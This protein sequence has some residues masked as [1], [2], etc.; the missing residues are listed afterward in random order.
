VIFDELLPNDW[1]ALDWAIPVA[2]IMLFAIIAVV[3]TYAV[4]IGSFRQ[5]LLLGLLKLSAFVLLAICLLEPLNRFSYPEPGANLMLVLADDSQSLQIKDRGQTESRESQVKDTISESS[6][7][8]RNLDSDFDVRRYQFDRRLRPVANFDSYAATQRGSDI[9]GNLELA[10]SRFEGRP[11]AGVLLFTDGNSTELERSTTLLAEMDWSKLPPIYPVVVGKDRPAN[12][13]AIVKVSSSQTNFESAPVTVTAEV[14]ATGYQGQTICVQL[15]DENN[16]ELARQK[17]ERVE[18]DRPFAVRF[19]TKSAQRGVNVFRV[20]TFPESAG[21]ESAVSDASIEATVVN[22]ERTVIVDRGRGPYRV[23]YVTGRPN[24]ELKFLRRAMAGDPEVNLVALVRIAKRQ[25]KFTFRGRAG[26]ESNPLFRGFDSQDD[27]TTEQH[28]EPVFLRLGTED[29]EELREGF[30]KDS[31]TLF[32]YDAIVLDDIEA[33]FFT[34]DQKSLLQKFVSIRGG[35][36]L[37]LGGQESFAAGKYARTPIGEM[38]PVYLDA[39][40]QLPA[41]EYQLNLTR[42]GWLQPWVRVEST[43]GLERKRLI[44]MP[45][46]QTVNLTDSIK[47]G[48]TVLATIKSKEGKQ[49]PALVVQAFGKGRTAAL[50][51]GDWWRWHMRSPADNDDLMKS[52]RQTLR[53]LVA[54]VPRRV[55]PDVKGKLDSAQSV[56]ITADIRDENYKPFDNAT[57]SVGVSTPDGKT[58]ELTGRASD[59]QPGRYA[60]NFSPSV[61]GAYRAKVRAES[62]DGSEIEERET[63]WVSD[64]DGDEFRSLVPN[65]DFLQELANRSGGE[66]IEINQLDQFVDS[67]PNR[68]IPIT[69]TRTLPWWHRWTIFTIALSLLVIEWGIRRWKG[70]P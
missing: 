44:E 55:E 52:W 48:A 11:S 50:M 58:I 60:T 9:V 16:E 30:P 43:E 38:M 53:W 42:E 67:L 32:Q 34:E 21:E 20:R 29:K 54:D 70:L 37:M 40:P 2:I 12:D 25:A 7:W 51:I 23:L 39:V 62:A 57:V 31:E 45:G 56:A 28:D 66:V 1:G 19:N 63:G 6:D 68:K 3:W 22:N 33:K 17:V 10:T 18:N 41:Q 46:F 64:P 49:H 5:K 47:P 59:E 15:L 61:P 36:L 65:R 13:L 8:L 24:W 14:V 4:S 35:G 69:E 26:Q 27:D